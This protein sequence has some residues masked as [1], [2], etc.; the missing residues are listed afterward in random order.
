MEN[1]SEIISH[2]NFTQTSKSK[3]YLTS[4]FSQKNFNKNQT[5]YTQQKIKMFLENFQLMEPI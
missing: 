5:L 1:I 4:F 3:Q 2:F